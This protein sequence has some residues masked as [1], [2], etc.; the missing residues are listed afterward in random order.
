MKGLKIILLCVMGLFLYSCDSNEVETVK[1]IE[2]EF[3]IGGYKTSKIEDIPVA[4]ASITY[5]NVEKSS[6]KWA[7]DSENKTVT[8]TYKDIKV[9]IPYSVADNYYT[10]KY[11]DITAC[12]TSANSCVPFV[13]LVD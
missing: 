6:I 8:G 3:S 11:G 10:V 4:V 5:E 12:I 13:T 1:S 7:N 9:F 2:V